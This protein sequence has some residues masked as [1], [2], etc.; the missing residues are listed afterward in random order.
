MYNFLKF[1]TIQKY[2]NRLKIQIELIFFTNN[3]SRYI[4]YVKYKKNNYKKIK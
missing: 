1:E 4:I 3:K 2:N